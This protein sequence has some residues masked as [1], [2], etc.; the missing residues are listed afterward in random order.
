MKQSSPSQSNVQQEM[1][2]NEGASAPQQHSIS[3]I[4]NDPLEAEER[5]IVYFFV[6]YG[7]YMIIDTEEEKMTVA[8]FIYSELEIDELQ[9]S[10]KLYQSML[11][12]YV[13]NEQLQPISSERFF[14]YHQNPDFSRVASDVLS[15]QYTLSNMFDK[16]VEDWKIKLPV[17][18]FDTSRI[19]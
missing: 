4:K 18:R 8:E 14:T 12:E 2:I 6:K 13:K 9:F 11:D 3:T 17:D 10:N 5:N 7:D 1:P 19:T 16:N 15:E